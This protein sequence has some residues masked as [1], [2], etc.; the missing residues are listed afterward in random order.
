MGDAP[1]EG[2]GFLLVAEEETGFE[3]ELVDLVSEA[4]PE[5]LGAE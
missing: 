4:G 2:A 5:I 3:T 1:R